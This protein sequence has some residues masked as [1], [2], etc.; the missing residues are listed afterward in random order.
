MYVHISILLWSRDHDAGLA[1]PAGCR[2][3]S[4]FAP[5]S[6]AKNNGARGYWNLGITEIHVV[7][8]TAIFRSEFRRYSSRAKLVTARYYGSLTRHRIDTRMSWGDVKMQYRNIVGMAA[9]WHSDKIS[10][11]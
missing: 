4:N 8:V 6:T 7:H 5:V 9:Y 11:E 2:A 1:F 3:E 10:T